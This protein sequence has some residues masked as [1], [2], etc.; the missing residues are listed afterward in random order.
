MGAL[1]LIINQVHQALPVSTVL[2]KSECSWLFTLSRQ[3]WDRWP[4]RR[5]ED[6]RPLAACR[7]L[8]LFWEQK[9]I[10][11]TYS[12]HLDGFFTFIF[13]VFAHACR[14]VC[15]DVHMSTD[16]SGGQQRAL[17]LTELEELV[18]LVPEQKNSGPVGAVP[19]LN[20]CHLSSTT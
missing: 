9:C 18:S 5:E 16:V 15:G 8:L 14:S 17:D 1:D 2:A 4:G 13:I 20:H 12:R 3:V 6:D 11:L 7:N 10:F 19:S